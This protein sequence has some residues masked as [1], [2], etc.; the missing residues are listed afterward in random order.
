MG[1]AKTR[2][3]YDTS[4]LLVITFL[5]GGVVGA[6]LYHAAF[7]VGAGPSATAPK[8]GM[9]DA[10]PEA[11]PPLPSAAETDGV[12]PAHHLALGVAGT[13]MTADERTL[14]RE[15]QPA[16]LL[17]R[18][19]NLR[20]A[21]QARALVAEARNAVGRDGLPVALYAIAPENAAAPF[22]TPVRAPAAIGA[23][24]D[25]AAAREAGIAL[26]A[27]AR[28]R[29]VN[30]LLLPHFDLYEEEF[31]DPAWREGLFG[32]DHERV[33]ALAA[34]FAR[35]LDEGG[36]IAVAGRFPGLGAAALDTDG[37]WVIDEYDVDL[38]AEAMW[39]FEVAARVPV[40]GIWTAH[41]ALPA[42]H[43]EAVDLPAALSPKLV[44][45][46]IRDGW[47]YAG[48]VVADDL[49]TLNRERRRREDRAF[50]DALAAGCD[51]VLLARPTRDRVQALASETLRA[52]Q[53]GD[54]RAENL[55]ESKARIRQ[56]ADRAAANVVPEP[57]P[58]PAPPP[59]APPPP[60]PTAEP[61]AEVPP[62]DTTN[63]DPGES[64]AA[65]EDPAPT[66]HTADDADEPGSEPAASAPAP[67]PAAARPEPAPQ[68]PGTRRIR[69]TIARGETLAAIAQRH[70]VSVGDL[71]AWNALEDDDIKY[72]RTLAVY[73]ADS[74]APAPPPSGNAAP[75][76]D[77]REHTV[78]DGETVAAIAAEYGVPEAD[79]RDWNSLP[80]G[81]EPAPGATIAVHLPV[82]LP[83]EDP[84][85]ADFGR[86]V[87]QVGDTLHRIALR[88]GTTQAEL[89]RLNDLR[90]PNAIRIGQTLKVP[91]A[92][93]GPA[94]GAVD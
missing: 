81:E 20:D 60:P 52:V 38:L 70:G 41:A 50:T 29:G 69:H 13:A 62:S 34:A 43:P 68:P 46:I 6:T 92:P 77:H 71:K 17:L 4:I 11:L 84:P 21:A 53:T 61:A 24:N 49:D 28:A 89:I 25:A 39:P 15:F 9:P 94:N 45:G 10:A 57:A 82:A 56:W 30:A 44:R 63:A 37:A 76:A 19:D 3:R 27:E 48:V 74:A 1:P 72:G 59:V 58:A 26:A 54:L 64:E 31:S 22:G 73:L 86:H 80:G 91:K 87:V 8:E 66:E 16:V 18:A 42:L 33:G 12:W 93:G 90:D 67:K 14:F 36:V 78:A 75:S 83:P 51:L 32:G 85:A 7:G 40:P 79:L 2:R 65:A 88:H 47:R 35:G 55:A 5:L 23:A